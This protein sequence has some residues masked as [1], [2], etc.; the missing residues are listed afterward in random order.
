ELAAHREKATPALFV[1]LS[2]EPVLGIDVALVPL[3]NPV[4]RDGAAP[5]LCTCRQMHA[6]D[7]D[8]AVRGI[9]PVLDLQL[10]I[11]RLAAA[12]DDEAVFLQRVLRRG[13]TDD[14]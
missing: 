9:D 8:A 10:E 1:N 3:Q 5:L 4:A 2:C 13:L 14:R 12:P 6:S 11:G 7:L